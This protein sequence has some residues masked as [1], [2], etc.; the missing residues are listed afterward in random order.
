MCAVALLGV[1]HDGQA[2]LETGGSS[3]GG[4]LL[5]GNVQLFQTETVGI[6]LTSTGTTSIA[7]L[8]DDDII[9]TQVILRA[10]AAVSVTVFP[11]V[12]F[13]VGATVLMSG[14][15]LYGL[16]TVNETYS[17]IQMGTG[18]LLP[19]GTALNLVVVTGAT[20]TTLTVTAYPIGLVLG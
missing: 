11:N 10:T 17:F 4:S 19:S 8:S 7:N 18:L 5:I 1:V 20:A 14:Q 6:D 15:T 13:D 16:D 12:R 3:S 2:G 9:V